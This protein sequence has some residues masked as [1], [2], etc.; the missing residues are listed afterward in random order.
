MGGV[1]AIVAFGWVTL[2]IVIFINAI[3]AYR[4]EDPL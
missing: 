3:E 1:R 2:P 4:I